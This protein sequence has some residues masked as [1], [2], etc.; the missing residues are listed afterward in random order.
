MGDVDG[1]GK[2]ELSDARL[3][4]N[5]ALKIAMPTE[6]QQVAADVNQDGKITIEDAQKIL[7]VALKIETF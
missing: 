5:I 2:I 4:L 6:E 7:R 1:N 3:A